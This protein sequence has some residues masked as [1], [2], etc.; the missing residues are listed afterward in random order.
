[1]YRQLVDSNDKAVQRGISRQVLDPDSRYYGGTIDPS[2]GI[3]WVNHTT[4]TPTDMCYWG[5]AIANPDSIFYRDEDLLNRLQ[6]ASEYVLRNQHGDGSISPGWTNSH[7]PPDT[8][9][10]V[11]GYAQL[12]Q[13]LQQQDWEPL[14]SVLNNMRLFSGTNCSGLADWRLSY[15]ESS[16]GAMRGAR[17]PASIV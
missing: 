6:L 10:L 5:A 15:A 17:F 4:G 13:L 1:M 12:Y 7:S 14:Q 2:T 16:L 9:F 3:A 8:A 11:V